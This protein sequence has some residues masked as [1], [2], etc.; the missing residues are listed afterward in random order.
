MGAAAWKSLKRWEINP[1]TPLGAYD[2][3]SKMAPVTRANFTPASWAVTILRLA[4]TVYILFLPISYAA[5][6]LADSTLIQVNKEQISSIN[7]RLKNLEGKVDNYQAVLTQLEGLRVS[8]AGIHNEQERVARWIEKFLFGFL[9]LGSEAGV[10]LAR[11]RWSR[12]TEGSQ[13]AAQ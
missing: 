9:A 4:L 13:N 1:L 6:S 10:R 12:K 11:G 7:E 3:L 2:T 8:L 5:Q